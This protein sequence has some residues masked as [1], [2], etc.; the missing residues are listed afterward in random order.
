MPS[1]RPLKLSTVQVKRFHVEVLSGPSRG[2]LREPDRQGVLRVGRGAAQGEGWLTL[3]DPSVSEVHITFESDVRG[4]N[5]R[6]R[7]TN[8][9]WIGDLFLHRGDLTALATTSLRVGETELMLVVEATTR[10]LPPATST[11]FGALTGASEGMRRV[12]ARAERLAE[13]DLPVLLTGESG[14]GKTALAREIH[15]RS[16]RGARGGPYLTVDCAQLVDSLIMSQLFGHRKGAFQGANADRPGVFEEAQGGTVF[17][18]EFGELSPTAQAA[19]LRVVG[20]ERV[21]Q[22]VGETGR[23]RP[24]DVRVI[25]ATNRDLDLDVSERRFRLD[26]YRRMAVGT[27][28]LPPLRERLDEFDGLVDTLVE[29]VRARGRVDVPYGF[30]MPADL[31]AVMRRRRWE[32]NVR[33]L[34]HFIERYLVL[35]EAPPEA[36]TR[37]QPPGASVAVQDLLDLKND[38][39]LL[40]LRRRFDRLYLPHIKYVHG[41]VVAA[42]RAREVD[43]ATIWRRWKDCGLKDP[44]EPSE[45]DG[46]D[47]GGR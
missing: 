8:G 1:T 30:V 3:D 34:V 11:R 35:G 18:D 2:E 21:V 16:K 32:G 44:A 47:G 12:F 4:V 24:V 37:P 31:R 17:L 15:A 20:E 45:G 39:A 23:D 25:A 14:T 28:H 9:T 7:S 38:P 43:R 41:G 19:L 36:E 5:L 26:L 42:A 10:P 27:I 46:G 29:V 22:R 33:E 6:E 13:S 40:E